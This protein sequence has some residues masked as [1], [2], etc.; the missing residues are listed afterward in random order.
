M[1]TKIKGTD[2]SQT[3]VCVCN[4]HDP[5]Y[6]RYERK[7]L[8][9]ASTQICLFLPDLS[10]A[11]KNGPSFPL[12]F[13]LFSFLFSL[14]CYLSCLLYYFLLFLFQFWNTTDSKKVHGTCHTAYISFHDS[15]HE[16][17]PTIFNQQQ[18]YNFWSNRSSFLSPASDVAACIWALATCCHARMDDQTHASRLLI[19][20]DSKAT[21]R[22][23]HRS[24]AV[25]VQ[26]W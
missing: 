17:A 22:A 7:S 19:H 16:A 1:R 5:R 14:L 18:R 23:S 21:L 2:M 9:G 11:V 20:Q 10:I 24:N 4:L 13:S 26:N 8:L 3:V 15:S 25:H 12:S 6:R